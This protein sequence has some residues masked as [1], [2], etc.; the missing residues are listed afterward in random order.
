[1]GKLLCQVPCAW[2]N[3]YMNPNPIPLDYWTEQA[4]N[5]RIATRRAGHITGPNVAEEAFC[6]WAASRGWNLSRKGW[7]DFFCWFDGQVAC[8]EVKP[9]GRERLSD[10]QKGVMRALV[11][12]GIPCYRWTPDRGLR[13]L[14][15]HSLK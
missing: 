5:A 11:A 9:V 7:P 12:A 4:H 8:V 15:R 2:Y 13:R 6:D 1:M 14:R 10:S 3:G